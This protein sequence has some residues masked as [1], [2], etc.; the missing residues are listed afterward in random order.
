MKNKLLLFARVL[1]AIALILAPFGSTV[2]YAVD[3]ETTATEGT[4]QEKT[5]DKSIVKETNVTILPIIN[6]MD[7][8][9]LRLDT[10]QNKLVLNLDDYV[11]K[12]GIKETDKITALVAGE[13]P[14]GQAIESITY[15]LSSFGKLVKKSS[16]TLTNTTYA[17]EIA[18]VFGDNIDPEGDG[19]TITELRDV[20]YF[21][22]NEIEITAVATLEDGSTQ[23]L[24]FTIKQEEQVISTD[25]NVYLMIDPIYTGKDGSFIDGKSESLHTSNNKLVLNIDDHIELDGLEDSDRWNEFAYFYGADEVGYAVESMIYDFRPLGN[26][27]NDGIMKSIT[28]GNVVALADLL[29]PDADP[30]NDGITIGALK[31]LLS[32]HN[33]S[34]ELKGIATRE[35]GLKNLVTIVIKQNTIVAPVEEEPEVMEEDEPETTQPE[36]DTTTK[37]EAK[38]ETDATTKPVE[39]PKSEGKTE[40]TVQKP[41]TEVKVQPVTT[42]DNKKK[43]M[44]ATVKVKD[45]DQVKENEVLVLEPK[46]AND[47]VELNVALDAGVV[48]GLKQKNAELKINKGDTALQIPTE[49][50]NQIITE[51]N[52][53]PVEIKLVKQEAKDALGSVYDYTIKAGSKVVS[54]FNGQAVTLTFEV[55]TER[56]SE[57]DPSEVKA[58]YYNEE[59]KEWEVL[60]DSSYDPNTGTV[61]ATTTH[62][63]TYGVFKHEVDVTAGGQ[64][65]TKVEGAGDSANASAATVVTNEKET[66]AELPNTATSLF[67]LLAIGLVFVGIGSVLYFRQ[68]KIKA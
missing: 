42:V 31:Q 48:D 19:I 32:N 30:E 46:A 18:K 47:Q 17:F 6:D 11:E 23:E 56:V 5:E 64:P 21:L 34:I 66:A 40:Q 43:Q 4:N 68:R 63:S 2:T 24:T 25:R 9:S 13:G 3:Q 37:P 36:K 39:K 16:V 58:F 44:T 59:T 1:T 52:N 45:I 35:N 62:F 10:E 26:A 60:E 54:D 50:L 22:D 8:L 33:G 57:L 28:R 49:I 55:N 51:A 27:M 20:L 53:A 7:D 29:S 65:V 61:T 15:D 12:H 38:P 67:N 14:G 41:K